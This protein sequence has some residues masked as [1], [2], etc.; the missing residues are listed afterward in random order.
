[1][2]DKLKELFGVSS[3]SNTKFFVDEK[4]VAGDSK[5]FDI[6]NMECSCGMKLRI[7][8]FMEQTIAKNISEEFLEAHKD[9]GDKIRKYKRE[10]A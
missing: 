1:M 7:G 2:F 5:F 4:E 3:T 9:C 8:N 6:I 10:M